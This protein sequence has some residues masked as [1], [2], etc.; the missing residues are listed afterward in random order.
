MT[1][2]LLCLALAALLAGPLGAA[3][4]ATASDPSLREEFRRIATAHR[5]LAAYALDIE[6]QSGSAQDTIFAA[7]DCEAAGHCLR[8]IGAISVLET[9]KRVVVI[10]RNRR[11]LTVGDRKSAAPPADPVDV[12]ANLNRW[13]SNGGAV[14]GGE[15]T[16]Q[17]RHWNFLAPKTGR[18]VAE[19]Y[20]DPHSRLLRRYVYRVGSA[21]GSM[22]EVK[23]NYTWRVR[24]AL[25]R[26][27]FREE[28]YLRRDGVAL[29]PAA[30]Y[31]G[32]QVVRGD[33]H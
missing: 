25:E 24:S 23:V 33:H 28:T 32:Y 10:D 19:L 15:L 30:A 8:R 29:S 1:G 13:E 22:R 27:L 5:N 4:A 3:S 18:V 16:A 17:G 6:A 20:T 31:T 21:D 9:P 2:T 26:R 14:S 11:I 12:L 7:V